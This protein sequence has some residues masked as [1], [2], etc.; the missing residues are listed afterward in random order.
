LQGY[1]DVIPTL[2]ERI[3]AVIEKEQDFQQSE[4]KRKLTLEFI[5][6][7]IGQ[8]CGLLTVIITVGA[9][10]W[11]GSINQPWPATALGI[12]GAAEIVAVFIAGRRRKTEIQGTLT[13]MAFGVSTQQ[14]PSQVSPS[15]PKL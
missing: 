9:S 11:L 8:S 13:Q 14:R 12:G 5:T 7:C 3:I 1:R 4:A 6:T 2:P 15:Q 10:I